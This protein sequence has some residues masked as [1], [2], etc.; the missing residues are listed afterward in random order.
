MVLVFYFA[1]IANLKAGRWASFRR[2]ESFLPNGLF[3]QRFS[4]STAS[5]F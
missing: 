4:I 5:I 1:W 2:Q 3:A